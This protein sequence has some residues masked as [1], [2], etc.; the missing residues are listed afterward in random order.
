[1]FACRGC[2]AAFVFMRPGKLPMPH[3]GTRG[4]YRVLRA[5][6]LG[7]SVDLA[8]LGLVSHGLMGLLSV[9]FGDRLLLYLLALTDGH[10]PHR[11]PYV[12]GL[13]CRRGTPPCCEEQESRKQ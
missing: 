10:R 5:N 8:P 4:P 13:R 12:A 11:L 6:Y 7:F 3:F 9:F 2:P 1:M